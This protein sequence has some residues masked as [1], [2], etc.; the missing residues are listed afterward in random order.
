MRALTVLVSF[1]V[2][3]ALVLWAY[4]Q[5]RGE[6]LV[7]RG[8]ELQSEAVALETELPKLVAIAKNRTEFEQRL[9]R[10]ESDLAKLRSI[11]PDVAGS[12]AVVRSQL[13]EVGAVL[14]LDPVVIAEASASIPGPVVRPTMKVRLRSDL[15]RLSQFLDASCRASVLLHPQKIQA[16]IVDGRGRGTQFEAELTVQA[17]AYRW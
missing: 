3:L 6:G 4:V 12:E 17:V 1:G 7:V 8:L 11:V 10:L 13:E 16:E 5:V 9:M 15:K 14:K 2:A